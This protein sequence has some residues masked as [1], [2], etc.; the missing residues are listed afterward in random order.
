MI[1]QTELKQQLHYNPDTGIFTR[2]VAKCRRFKAGD[3]AGCL[4]P[5]GYILIGINGKLYRAHRLAWLY[6]YGK[7]PK[8]QIDHINGIKSDN[9]IANLRES[10]HAE[11]MQN[12]IKPRSNNTS[13][14]LGVSWDKNRGNFVT[15]ISINGKNK[16]LGY[17]EI[18]AEAHQVYLEAKRANH[19]F[20]TI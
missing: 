10:T 4:S 11:N 16:H 1:T 15:S 20:C 14:Y 13:G 6:V 5:N 17:F 12:E 2:L 7:F 19:E 8:D 3:I 18:A 9:R